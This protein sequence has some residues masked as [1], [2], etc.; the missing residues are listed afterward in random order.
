MFIFRFINNLKTLF[1]KEIFYVLGMALLLNAFLGILFYIFERH[2][3]DLSLLDGLWWAMVTMT[4]VGYG[5][6]SA[7][8]DIGR[9]LISYPCMLLGIGIIGYLIGTVTNI[10]IEFATRSRRGLMDIEFKNHV[11]ICNYPGDKKIFTIVKEL[12]DSPQY[13]KCK[14]VLVTDKI[15]E[16]TE[17]LKKENIYFIYGSPTDE[18]NL[19]RANILECTGV[20]ILAEDPYNKRSDERTFV[21]GSLIEL[22]EK[23]KN[24]PIKTITEVIES[25]NIRNMKRAQIDGFISEDGLTGRLIVQEFI[26]PGINEVISQVLTNSI[27]SQFYICDTSLINYQIRDVQI[28]ALEHD[29]NMQVIGITRNNENLLNPSKDTVINKGDKLIVLAENS[30]DYKIIESE[31]QKK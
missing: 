16:L 24:I 22:I 1:K 5:D 10:L 28:S 9:F 4:T 17:N 7:K 8:T 25:N 18:N 14:F 29:I 31:L 23:D 26:N 30:N 2:V 20:I 27:G 12:R 3:Q 15:T 11:I 21:I 13:T 6:I 19:Y